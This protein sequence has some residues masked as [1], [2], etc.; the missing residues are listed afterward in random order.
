MHK[1]IGIFLL[2]LVPFLV[3]ATVIQVPG[4]YATIQTAINATANGDTVLVSPGLYA[5]PFNF[6]GQHITLASHYLVTGEEAD[7]ENT[8]LDGGG[9]STILTITGLGITDAAVIGFSFQNGLGTGDW[10]NVH[11]GGIHVAGSSVE[12]S[13]CNFQDCVTS[14]SSNRGAGIYYGSEDGGYIGY[15]TF[16]NLT[17]Y[18][19]TAI[20]IANDSYNILIEHCEAYDNVANYGSSDKGIFMATY[21]NLIMFYR[22]L[23]HHNDGSGFRIWGTTNALMDHC[24]S[25]DNTTHAI[26]AMY[27]GNDLY[28]TNTIAIGGDGYDSITQGGYA[29]T[30]ACTFSD[31]GGGAEF[32]WFGEGCFDE[33]PMFEDRQN[34]DYHLANGSPCIDAG[35]PD[36]PWDPDNT[37]P[38]VGA[39][40]G[41]G[42]PP[43]ALLNLTVQ[44]AP[45]IIPPEGGIVIFDAEIISNLQQ[46]QQAEAWLSALL[47]NGQTFEP[48]NLVNVFVPVGTTNIY[49]LG[50]EVPDMAPEGIYVVTGHI[51]YWPNFMGI[52]DSFTFEKAG[53]RPGADGEWSGWGWE[54]LSKLDEMAIADAS[55]ELP[56][57]YE[58]APIYPNPFNASATVSLSL[59]EISE[60]RVSVFNSVGQE[61]KVLHEG[62]LTAGTQTLSF[63]AGNLASGLYFVHAAIP[64]KLNQ[65]QKVM[66]VR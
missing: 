1:G 32:P 19:G 50:L 18:F 10:P 30:L 13:Y 14:G 2:L 21:S 56:S 20:A 54:Q 65:V 53:I 38:D 39:Y 5:G 23:A 22:C 61:V 26:A 44:N 11:G 3:T 49:N 57:S 35:D 62:S 45:V 28:V 17:S 31:I 55:T 4:D 40:F 48:I 9:S 25:A 8:V 51:G 59:P 7:I 29:N 64:G 24:T 37:P 27:S 12:I 33:D 46:G 16:S 36:S 63:D 52:E 66:L 47:P 43:P 15:C 6:N 58:L 41:A 60:L 42:E 34:Y